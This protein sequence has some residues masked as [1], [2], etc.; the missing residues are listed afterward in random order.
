MR[1]LKIFYFRKVLINQAKLD[2]VV[3][4]DEE[5]DAEIEK[6]IAYFESQLGTIEKVEE[7]FGK[8][9]LEIELELGKIIKDQFLAQKVQ[10]TIASD[11]KVTPC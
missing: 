6:R 3:V 7:Y 4:S 10:G 5:I 9:K 11:V 1:L 8:I 2:S